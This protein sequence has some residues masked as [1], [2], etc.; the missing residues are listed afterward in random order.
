MGTVAEGR[1][2]GRRG[3]ASALTPWADSRFWLL[4]LVVLALALIRLALTVAFHLDPMSIGVEFST[5]LIFVV[6]V[7]VVSLNDGL[8]G[9]LVTAAWI[10]VL[11]IPRFVVA[12]NRGEPS[13][14]WAEA[15]QLVV[16]FALALLVGQRVTSEARSRQQADT[17]LAAR[18]RAEALYQDIFES[19]SSPILIVDA[20]G[21]VIQSNRS[22]DRAFGTGGAAGAAG[23]RLVDVVGAEASALVLGK[24]VAED[25]VPGGPAVVRA[26]GRQDGPADDRRDP[27]ADNAAERSVTPVAFTIHGES[28]LY[29]PSATPVGPLGADR[30]MQVIFEDVTA[31]TRR[32]DLLEAYANQVVLGQEEERRHIA[33]ELHDGPLQALIHLCRQIDAVDVRPEADV[34]AA[35][36]ASLAS[37]RTTVEETVAELR[38][39]ARGLR[40]SILD[41]LGLVASLNQVVVE[42]TGR[43]GL[44][45]E[46]QVSGTERRLPPDVELAVFR[47]AQEAVT[48]VERHASARHL[49][50]TLEF[51]DRSLRLQ[52]ADDGI[53]FSRHQQRDSRDGYSLGL[54]G[55]HERARLA[56]GRLVVRSTPGNGTVVEA[57]MPVPS[58]TPA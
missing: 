44:A 42:A 26:G 37:M 12:S 55:M 48:N 25:V 31:E 50:V 38:S 57:R 24:L 4:Q 29:R 45:G 22:A 36:S 34:D 41:D 13:A 58:S 51:N 11:S 16:L 27:D 3:T 46:F 40:P 14:V 33:Q 6:P 7:V 23:R 30:R 1:T 52:V 17:S 49:T 18:L 43:Q 39:I 54:P 9:G 32:H 15:L 19:N 56:G 2:N 10:A 35:P 47:I 53:G 8:I 5:L 20:D 28:I 21:F